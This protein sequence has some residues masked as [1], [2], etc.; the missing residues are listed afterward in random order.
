MSGVGY[1]SVRLCGWLRS[2]FAGVGFDVL[3]MPQ[4]GS[5]ERRRLFVVW[6]VTVATC[7]AAVAAN[8]LVQM[9]YLQLL[10]FHIS[11]DLTGAT[12]VA[13]TA[14]CVATFRWFR[15]A[16]KRTTQITVRELRR[17][18][19]PSMPPVKRAGDERR[20]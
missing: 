6:I 15:T 3:V 16:P 13:A 12:Y 19:R 2:A 9:P 10:G 7:A 18:G 5:V 4:Y 1:G 20:R 8:L 14:M 11:T 17:A